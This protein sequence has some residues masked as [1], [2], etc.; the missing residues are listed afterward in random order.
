MTGKGWQR[1]QSGNPPPADRSAPIDIAALAREHGPKC[2][3][4]VVELLDDPDSRIRLAAATVLI[5]RGYG[6]PVQP[7]ANDP[8]NPLS[9][10]Y[11]IEMPAAVDGKDDWRRKY[12][13]PMI[14]TEPV[15]G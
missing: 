10:R 15:K 3:G 8:D 12:A 9:V 1:G 7:L 4:V 13:P 11:V 6:K 14:D 2:V 5:E